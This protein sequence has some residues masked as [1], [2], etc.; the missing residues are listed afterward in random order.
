M[1]FFLFFLIFC[2]NVFLDFGV[3]VILDGI[4][5]FFMKELCVLYVG[6]IRCVCCIGCV[7]EI[8]MFFVWGFFCDFN[9]IFILWLCFIEF[10]CVV[11]VLGFW[12]FWEVE[13]DIE[14]I[15]ND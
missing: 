1:L 5:C 6:C 12:D 4:I 2:S 9:K 8:L 14:S 7:E 11:V 15:D 10:I 3:L 13:D